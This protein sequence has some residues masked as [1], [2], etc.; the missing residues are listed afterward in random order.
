M[1]GFIIHHI[2]TNC[3]SFCWIKV[4]VSGDDLSV[5]KLL[6]SGFEEVKSLSISIPKID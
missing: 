5:I 4:F 6:M 1:K 2:L 3:L